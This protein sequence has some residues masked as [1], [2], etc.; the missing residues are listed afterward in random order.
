MLEYWLWLSGRRGL[1]VRGLRALLEQ[2]GTPEAV[3]CASDAEYPS[4]IRP[5]GRTSL[6]DKELAPARQ[7]LQQCYRQCIHI[8]TLQ[9]AVYPQRLKNI[10]DAPLVLYYQG[11]LPDFDAEPVI[12]MVGTRRASA[13][14]LLQAKRLGYELGRYGAIVVSGGAAGIDTLALRGAVSSGTPPVAV[15]A[16][17]VDVDYPAANR[18]LFEDLRT[19]GCVMSE[20]PPGTP[21]L[22]E[23]FPSRNRILSGLALGSVVVEAPKKSGALITARHALEQGR[24]VFTL[25]G[26]LG[27][28]TCAGNIQLLKQGAILVEEG[29]DILQEYTYLYPELPQRQRPAGPMTLTAQEAAGSVVVAETAAAPEK[30]DTKAVD[31]QE[32]RAYIDVQEILPQVSPDEAAVLRLLEDGK[33]PVDRLIDET[34]LPAATDPVRA[35]AAGGQGLC[36][37]AAGEILRAGEKI[38]WRRLCRTQNR[39]WSSWNL[40]RRPKPSENI[41][42]PTIRS[43]PAWATCAICAKSTL[44]VDI[45]HDFEPEYYPLKGKEEIISE[46]QKAAKH[47]RP[48]LSRD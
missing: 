25:P 8:V 6:A 24:D 15:F 42:V 34:Q 17:G 3:Y 20:L 31:K 48:R 19:N 12:A 39:I 33:Q 36:Q 11:V 2:F 1:G 38:T 5:D 45:E 13:Y 4:D 29:W 35:H 47:A 21:P 18:S 16:C 40:R 43:R 32:N 30:T 27:N 10:D 44:S 22:P 41:S 9:D 37:A 7:I 23:H 26:N 14:G 28:P 46:L